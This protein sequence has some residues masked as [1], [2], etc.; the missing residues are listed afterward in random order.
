MSNL[1]VCCHINLRNGEVKRYDPPIP[2]PPR[3]KPIETESVFD[4]L[5]EL[6]EQN[7]KR[8]G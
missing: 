6:K 2:L 1:Y 4:H 3:K 8:R 5:W 7:E